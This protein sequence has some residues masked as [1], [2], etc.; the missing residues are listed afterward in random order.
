M[1][2]LSSLNV[3]GHFGSFWFTAFPISLRHLFHFV[4]EFQ[5]GAEALCTNQNLTLS[6][7]NGFQFC[8]PQ[9]VAQLLLY[10]CHDY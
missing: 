8:K 1:H 7:C 9:N 6:A 5:L 4:M 2:P 3:L 10:C